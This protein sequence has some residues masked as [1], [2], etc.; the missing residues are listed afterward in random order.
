MI[1]KLISTFVNKVKTRKLSFSERVA[2]GGA[3]VVLVLSAILG[4][5]EI[6]SFVY[7]NLQDIDLTA[8]IK[9]LI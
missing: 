9:S 4:H 5:N 3:G 7:D 1:N 6:I 2:Y 8:I